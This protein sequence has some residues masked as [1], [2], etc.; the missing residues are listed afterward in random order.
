MGMSEEAAPKTGWHALLGINFAIIAYILGFGAYLFFKGVETGGEVTTGALLLNMGINLLLFGAIPFLWV[1]RT[2]PDWRTW[3]AWGKPEG[4]IWGVGLGFAS[5]IVIGLVVYTLQT[6]GLN[7]DS[8]GNEAL[9]DAV[10]WKLALLVAAVAGISEEILFR[11]VL[12]NLIGK[13]P[14]AILFGLAHAGAGSVAAMIAT[15]ILGL[16]FAYLRPYVGLRGLIVAHFT[17]NTI[18]F[19]IGMVYG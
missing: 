1:L 11:G 4:I 16:L 2:K 13:V 3:L 5:L 12:Q 9:Q 18:I 7:T 10:D 17:Y 6:L 19:A 8:P 14:Q 15:G